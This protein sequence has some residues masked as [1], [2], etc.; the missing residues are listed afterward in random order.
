M[1]VTDIAVNTSGLPL[2]TWDLDPTHSTAS[3]AV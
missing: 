3:F 2:G 1:S